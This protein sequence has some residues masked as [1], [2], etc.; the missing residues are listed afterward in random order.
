MVG[1]LGL[2]VHTILDLVT[3]VLA[4]RNSSRMNDEEV[5]PWWLVLGWPLT[6]TLTYG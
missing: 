1:L 3:T 4:E 5:V 6:H 2:W